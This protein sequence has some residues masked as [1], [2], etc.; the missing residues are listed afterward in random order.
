MDFQVD[1]ARQ[2]YREAVALL[3]AADARAQKPGL[4]M[5]AIYYALLQEIAADG[6]A[7][8]LQ[9]KLAIPGP[10]KARIALKTWLLG[11]KP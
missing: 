3:P 4:I 10:R 1:R 6:A 9:Y 2:C 11:F 8:V 7:H 5:A